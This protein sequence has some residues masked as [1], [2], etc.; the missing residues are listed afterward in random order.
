MCRRQGQKGKLAAC[1]VEGHRRGLFGG[2]WV[3]TREG[4]HEAREWSLGPQRTGGAGRPGS[5]RSSPRLLPRPARSG[6]ATPAPRG[7][8]REGPGRRSQRL[9]RLRAPARLPV[10]ER[11]SRRAQVGTPAGNGPGSGAAEGGARRG[12][13]GWAEPRP[14]CARLPRGP[15]PHPPGG[16]GAASP[17][18]GSGSPP[19]AQHFPPHLRA[20]RRAPFPPL[21]ILQTASGR[22][23]GSPPLQPA[24]LLVCPTGS[25]RKRAGVCGWPPQGVGG[26]ARRTQRV[27][28]EVGGAVAGEP[29][30]ILLHLGVT[31]CSAHWGWLHVGGMNESL[32]SLS[33]SEGGLFEVHVLQSTVCVFGGV[34]LS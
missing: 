4:V 1:R 33:P 32:L 8:G 2:R 9:P 11:R 10:A 23:L 27:S 24:A 17:P 18:H 22:P 12:R 13:G 21:R 3:D 30:T 29:R 16:G 34:L 25:F 20:V 14:S 15:P 31:G 7:R 6:S 19:R 28:P 5:P 26:A